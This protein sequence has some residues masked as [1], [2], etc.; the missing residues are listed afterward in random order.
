MGL[1]VRALSSIMAC[2]W[3]YAIVAGFNFG[4]IA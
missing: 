4:L 3:F 2:I 1:F